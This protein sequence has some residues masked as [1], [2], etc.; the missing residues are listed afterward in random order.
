[1]LKITTRD[2]DVVYINLDYISCVKISPADD[3]QGIESSVHVHFGSHIGVDSAL[4]LWMS[5]DG[6][7]ELIAE[8]DRRSEKIEPSNIPF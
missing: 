4:F 2:R 7:P 8:L 3:E 6:V 1:M 5:D